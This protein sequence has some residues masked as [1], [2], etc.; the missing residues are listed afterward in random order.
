MHARVAFYRL[1]SGSFEEVARMV[2]A[3]GGL[4]EIF[5]DSPGFQSY[6]LVEAPAG[7]FS[8][9]HWDSSEQAEEANRSAATWVA[10]HVES[11]IKLV[12]SD[13]GEVVMSES[14]AH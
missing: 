6:E 3:P 1:R 8:V 2:E 14:A 13:I 11:R 4:L 7:L 10:E 12:Q 9:S 5:R